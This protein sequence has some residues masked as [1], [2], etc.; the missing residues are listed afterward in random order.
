MTETA[1][2]FLR[3]QFA[4]LHGNAWIAEVF[5]VVLTTAIV[6][7]IEKLTYKH[8]YPRFCRSRTVWD[9]TLISAL[10]KPLN[11]LIWLIGLSIAAQLV[12]EEGKNTAIFGLLSPLRSLGI[13][14]FFAWFALRFIQKA[15]KNY[16]DERV[17]YKHIDKTT[18]RAISKILKATVLIT[19]VL[20]AL[21]TF[22]IQISGVLAF[23]GISGAV[24]AFSAKDL[25]AN[26]FGGL[27]VYLDR[28]FVVGDWIRSPDRQIEGVVENIGWRL[29]RIRTFDKRPLYVPNSMFTNICIENPSRMTNRRIKTFI[30]LR[31][32]DA[33]KMAT[34]I[35]KVEAMLKEHPE[36]DHNQTLMVN[37]VEFAPS[38]LTFMVYTFTKTT[39]WQ[40]FQKVQQDIYLKI[41]DIVLR[42]GAQCAYPT[43][44]VHVPERFSQIQRPPVTHAKDAAKEM[45]PGF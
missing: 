9:D 29:C 24:V 5:V 37:L 22:G 13:I 8:L 19:S 35:E 40:Y 2:H 4:F 33:D 32:E 11:F 42:C 44:T 16:F 17:N 27:I 39:D 14:V 25:L 10:H 12:A 38:S 15:E 1:I 45:D 7:A 34:V 31:Y 23:G 6:V 28:P 30:G 36:I 26:F 18:V 43:T 21:Q 3:K 41:I 20:V